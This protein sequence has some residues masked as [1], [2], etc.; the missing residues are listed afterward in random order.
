MTIYREFYWPKGSVDAVAALQ[1][2][3]PD[4]PV[5]LNGKLANYFTNQIS[6]IDL[7]FSRNVAITS[8]QDLSGIVFTVSGLQNGVP[9]TEEIPG[10]NNGTIEGFL[11]F[12]IITSIFLDGVALEFQI[13]TG[14]I[15]YVSLLQVDT[16]ISTSIVNN[17]IQTLF[18]TSDSL[19]YDLY[20]TLAKLPNL[21][22]TYDDLIANTDYFFRL[23]TNII[24]RQL[25][26][27]NDV[28]YGYLIKI[29]ESNVNDDLRVIYMQIQ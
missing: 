5:E 3:T 17:S 11:A 19:T 12:D 24:A 14:T 18:T 16:A 27:Q 7:G 23:E 6:F 28:V 4:D 13:G 1:V 20:T 22:R 26:T 10:P 2:G 15:G 29:T 21:G 25:L 9:V 8:A